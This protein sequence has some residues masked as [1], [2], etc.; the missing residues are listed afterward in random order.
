MVFLVNFQK[1][2]RL[3]HRENGVENG[4]ISSSMKEKCEVRKKMNTFSDIHLNIKIQLGD[5][6]E[7]IFLFRYLL[8][9][10]SPY[11]IRAMEFLWH[12]KIQLSS[13]TNPR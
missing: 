12:T 6:N 13:K 10:E 11:Q 8:L 4:K 9:V 1:N 5:I 3:K 2:G 7:L